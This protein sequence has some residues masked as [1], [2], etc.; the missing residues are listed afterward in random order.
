M[1]QTGREW[2]TRREHRFRYGV[3]RRLREVQRAAH[4]PPLQ[5]D[6]RRNL[7]T[8]RGSMLRMS[9]PTQEPVRNGTAVVDCGVSGASACVVEPPLCSGRECG[10]LLVPQAE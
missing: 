10:L 1:S 3:G 5:T 9:G 6:A 8:A 4:S 7:K 2:P